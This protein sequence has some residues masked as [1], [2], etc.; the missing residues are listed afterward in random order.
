MGI[1]HTD[2]NANHAHACV[3]ACVYTSRG[4]R[5]RQLS[6]YKNPMQDSEEK[7]MTEQGEARCRNFVWPIFRGV[8]R[9]RLRGMNR[10]E[11]DLSGKSLFKKR[12]YVILQIYVEQFRLPPYY[13]WVGDL[14]P[15][16]PHPF[17]ETIRLSVYQCR[18]C[19]PE[20]GGGTTVKAAD[21]SCL[22][23]SD[24]HVLH[25]LN[26]WTWAFWWNQWIKL[27]RLWRE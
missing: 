9:L 10:E 3:C 18:S 7:P 4:R 16:T 15:V 21:R 22:K 13:I 27:K 14:T 5:G 8:F 24:A 12:N 19:R 17:S 20:W 11:T 23:Y 25:S 1:A 6:S 26:H 2:R